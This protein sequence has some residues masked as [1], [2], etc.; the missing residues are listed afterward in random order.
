MSGDSVSIREAI[1]YGL[2]SVSM[3]Q[4]VINI[5]FLVLGGL[6][7]L[8]NSSWW[9]ILFFPAGLTISF[10]YANWAIP[11]W[12]IW[13]YE[14]VSDIGQLERSAELANILAKQSYRDTSGFM[15]S[16][17]R[18]E[19]TKL[20]ERFDEEPVF[21]NDPGVPAETS[22]FFSTV[23]NNAA[24]I[25]LKE[26]GIEIS[27]EGLFKWSEIEDEHVATVGFMAKGWGGGTPTSGGMKVGYF[28]FDYPNGRFDMPLSSLNISAWELDL[29]LYTY[30]GRFSAK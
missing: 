22:L 29:L 27:E 1:Q 26:T 12:K 13:A 3:P 6:L 2:K 21:V 9:N 8:L 18:A 14:Q 30:R 24:S 25:V 5:S 7:F 15:S 10:I 16:S 23:L 11:R 17:Q 28:R 20:L 4:K 19:L